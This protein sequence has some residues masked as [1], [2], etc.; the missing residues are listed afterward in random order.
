MFKKGKKKKRKGKNPWPIVPSLNHDKKLNANSAM[1]RCVFEAEFQFCQ[2]LQLFLNKM[3]SGGGGSG[4][5]ARGGLRGY[6]RG[7][8]LR[9]APTYPIPEPGPHPASLAPT[10][11]GQ[12]ALRRFLF[13]EPGIWC[14][15][16]SFLLPSQ[17]TR[18]PW[19]NSFLLPSLAPGPCTVSGA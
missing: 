2:D 15:S 14:V 18:I 3:K 5:T 13:S 12:S 19:Q 17:V 6:L 4:P 8:R 16:V 1:P 10:L 11:H 9:G 7:E